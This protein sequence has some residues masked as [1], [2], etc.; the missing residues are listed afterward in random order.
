VTVEPGAESE[1]SS[2][3]NFFVTFAAELCI[4]IYIFLVTFAAAARSS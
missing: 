3:T 4:Y 2:K 1:R